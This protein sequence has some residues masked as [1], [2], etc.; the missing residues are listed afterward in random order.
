MESL[1]RVFAQFQCFQVLEL[2]LE[3]LISASIQKHDN[4]SASKF[5]PLGNAYSS[6]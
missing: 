2:E 4:V 5:Q 3:V 1:V 6:I